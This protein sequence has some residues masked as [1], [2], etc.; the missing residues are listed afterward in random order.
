M[1]ARTRYI[2]NKQYPSFTK[3]IQLKTQ[4]QGLATRAKQGIVGIGK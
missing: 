4:Q 1:R 3:R 2:I